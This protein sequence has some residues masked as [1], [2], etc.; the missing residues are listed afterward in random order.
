LNKF[1]I[2][3]LKEDIEENFPG[4]IDNDKFKNLDD[5]EKIEEPEIKSTVKKYLPVRDLRVKTLTSNQTAEENA[6]IFAALAKDKDDVDAIDVALATNMISVGLDVS[7][8]ALMIINGQPL[9]TA[10]YI[11]ASSRVG[12]GETPGI[13]YVN[14]YKTQARS[15]SHYENFRSYH[16]SFYRFVEPSSLTPFTFQARSRALH[17]ALVIAMRHSNIGLLAND[18]AG[19]FNL[20]NNSIKKV[21]KEMKIRCKLAIG[22]NKDTVFKTNAHID[23]LAERWW[24][25]VQYCDN[26]KIKLVYNSNDKSFNNLICNFN[27]ENGLWKTLQSMRNV[28]NAAML[29]LL[30]G[31]KRFEEK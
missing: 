2:E 12:R 3:S 17:A 13:V 10:E 30:K 16:D 22:K 1:T 18:M 31:V 6:Q 27:E 7:R 19:S 11:Q 21:I 8:L 26:N 5:F 24:S 28:E 25:E 9:T 14:Y 23:T 15:L 4:F 20:E 29:K